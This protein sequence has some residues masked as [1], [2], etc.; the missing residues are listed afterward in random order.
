M[1]TTMK[2][3]ITALAL[4]LITLSGFAQN[5]KAPKIDAS[6]KVMDANGKHMGNVDKH[7]VITN[8][9]GTKIAY[10]DSE[11]FLIDAKTGKK[12]G[13]GEKNGNFTPYYKETPDKGWTIDAPMNGTCMVKDDK[14]NVKALVHENYKQFGA[15]AAHCLANHMDHH[16]I[17]TEKKM[18]GDKTATSYSCSMH[19]DVKSDKPGK[20]PKCGMD[21]EAVK[22][23]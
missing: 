20:C 2:S 23:K 17:Q 3:F 21:L 9:E 13:K 4:I 18:D 22:T 19:P 14:G 12:M 11:G 5:Y 8:A 1:K 6:G 10:V 16:Q 7:G 15:C